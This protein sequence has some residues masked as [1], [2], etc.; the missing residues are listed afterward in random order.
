MYKTF[1]LRFKSLKSPL[2]FPRETCYN[3]TQVSSLVPHVIVCT[4]LYLTQ[5]CTLFSN[6]L[7][8]AYWLLNSF[9]VSSYLSNLRSRDKHRLHSATHHIHPQ[10][11][12]YYISQSQFDAWCNQT[13]LKQG[14]IGLILMNSR[15]QRAEIS[16]FRSSRGQ[17][18]KFWKSRDWFVNLWSCEWLFYNF[19]KLK[20]QFAI[21]VNFGYWS[22]N[23]RDRFAIFRNF[24]IPNCNFT[25]FIKKD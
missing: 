11:N 12:R 3:F 4:F 25:E 16:K 17:S 24:K 10:D 20:D 14:L 7:R 6:L 19:A 13:W 5:F 22:E 15:V 23:F 21:S 1:N 2:F 9:N 18:V 8:S